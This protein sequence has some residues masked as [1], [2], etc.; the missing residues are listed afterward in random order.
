[1]R[2]FL[3]PLA[4]AFATP[5][6]ARSDCTPPA[7]TADEAAPLVPLEPEAA[8]QPAPLAPLAAD[9]PWLARFEAAADALWPALRSGD[10]ARWRPML[11]GRWLSEGEGRAVE[12]LLADRC[13]AFAPLVTSAAPLERRIF[14][15]SLPA[16]YSSADRAQ[17]AARP[18][19]EALVCWAARTDGPPRWPRT[20]AE[21]DNGAGRPYAC[22]RIV[23]SIR[24][25]APQWRAFIERG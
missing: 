12:A 6:V 11:G 5:A 9:S 8:A 20:A 14:G 2:I 3:I 16:A 19:A 4:L 10:P 17:I 21:A 25:G 7:P 18:E 1:M 15:W 22:A 24:D 23:W 13:A